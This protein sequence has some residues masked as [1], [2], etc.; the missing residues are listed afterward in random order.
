MQDFRKK[1]PTVF[2]IITLSAIG[3]IKNIHE[4]PQSCTAVEQQPISAQ[5]KIKAPHFIQFISATQQTADF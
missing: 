2:P 4:K 5:L 3:E 1:N